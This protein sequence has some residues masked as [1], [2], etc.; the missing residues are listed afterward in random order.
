MEYW[1]GKLGKSSCWKE[2]TR[3]PPPAR[4]ISVNTW[5]PPRLHD[6]NPGRPGQAHRHTPG[7]CRHGAGRRGGTDSTVRNKNPRISGGTVGTA[8]GKRRPPHR[9]SGRR[10][11]R[12]W[13]ESGNGRRGDG[14]RFRRASRAPGG[15]RAC[16][17]GLDASGL[18]EVP[19][20]DRGP[21]QRSRDRG[22]DPARET[23]P[24]PK[25]SPPPPQAR[26]ERRVPA[27]EPAAPAPPPAGPLPA[28]CVGRGEK[29]GPRWRRAA[30]T[31]HDPQ[32]RGDPGGLRCAVQGSQRPSAPRSR[33]ARST[34]PRPH[35]RPARARP[36]ASPPPRA[37]A[38]P[39]R[40]SE[41]QGRFGR[42]PL[43]S[44]SPRRGLA[45]PGARRP[46]EEGRGPARR[47]PGRPRAPP[48]GRPAPPAAPRRPLSDG[49]RFAGPAGPRRVLGLTIAGPPRGPPRGPLS[50][51]PT[52][53]PRLGR[54]RKLRGPGGCRGPGPCSSCL[55]GSAVFKHMLNG[56][57]AR[58]HAD[59]R[60]VSVLDPGISRVLF[61]L[62]SGTNQSEQATDSLSHRTLPAEGL[63]PGTS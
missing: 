5:E 54:L 36:P 61:G 21:G 34:Y 1:P 18:L 25:R 31:H 14:G 46:M 15:P 43:P 20:R 23:P 3:P 32:R 4:P 9:G 44:P 24:L 63:I 56:G 45:G 30:P 42:P 49:R 29:G 50:A 40:R 62:K 8:P 16:N 37:R 60:D 58:A 47:G 33:R 52:P 2:H 28:Q 10:E 12:V 55:L 48:P 53:S 59:L 41:L 6:A 17:R 11:S 38:T 19:G 57:M 26:R 35:P 13:E 39:A 51:A 7:D 22:P 27:V